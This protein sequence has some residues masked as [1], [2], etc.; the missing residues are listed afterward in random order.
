VYSLHRRLYQEH[1]RHGLL[2]HTK[3]IVL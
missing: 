2:Q 3:R 1:L